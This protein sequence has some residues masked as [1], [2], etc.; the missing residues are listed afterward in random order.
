MVNAWQSPNAA[1]IQNLQWIKSR[2]SGWRDTPVRILVCKAKKKLKIQALKLRLDSHKQNF[3]CLYTSF[4][5]TRDLPPSLFLLQQYWE[6]PTVRH[7]C[8]EENLFHKPL[9]QIFLRLRIPKKGHKQTHCQ[10]TGTAPQEVHGWLELGWS[11]IKKTNRCWSHPCQYFAFHL[12]QSR[13][14]PP[15]LCS[16]SLHWPYS[17]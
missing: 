10:E 7:P 8:T 2:T 13:Q 4:L 16:R 11:K 1:A 17:S 6:A 3:V 15:D 9:V 12:V 5:S 14:Y